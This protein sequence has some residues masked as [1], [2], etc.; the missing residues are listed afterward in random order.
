MCVYPYTLV[1]GTVVHVLFNLG[2]KDKESFSLS[3]QQISSFQKYI[4]LKEWA[5]RVCA[6]GMEGW[7]VLLITTTTHL[8]QL[9]GTPEPLINL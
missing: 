1:V 3:I 5:A 7:G 9:E 8:G 2:T 6:E 4:S